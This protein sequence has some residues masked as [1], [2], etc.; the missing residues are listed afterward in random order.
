MMSKQLFLESVFSK[1]IETI[2]N[3]E[4]KK[5]LGDGYTPPKDSK[6]N[7]ITFE[8]IKDMTQDEINKNWKTVQEVLKNSNK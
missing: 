1:H 2:V 8:S 3:E 7:T 4:V 6:N 5:R